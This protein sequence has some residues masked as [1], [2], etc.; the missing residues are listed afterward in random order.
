MERNSGL[1]SNRNLAAA[2]ALMALVML[3]A[4]WRGRADWANH[5]LLL[6]L[7]IASMVLILGLTGP[8]LLLPKGTRRHRLMGRTWAALMF[9]N[10]IATL[11]FNAAADHGPQPR[12]GGVFVGDVSPIHALSLF[13]AV[14]VPLAVQRARAHDVAGHQRAIRGLVIGSLLVA[15]FFTLPFGRLMGVWLMGSG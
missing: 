12:W 13:V 2:A 9:G 8:M 11:F 15:G 14:M 6:Q 4:I 5:S 7:H 3:T 10:A 1:F